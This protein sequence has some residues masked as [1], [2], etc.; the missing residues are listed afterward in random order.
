MKTVG[1]LDKRSFS[2]KMETETRLEKDEELIESKKEV[3]VSIDS[4][5][6]IFIRKMKR[7]RMISGI[8]LIT[9]IL[10]LK[11]L[12]HI[13]YVDRF[14]PLERVRVLVPGRGEIGPS[15]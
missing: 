1:D 11:K 5:L 6:K 4:M 8:E 10:F 9:C 15:P 13:S 14:D 12:G 3:I 2:A 7:S